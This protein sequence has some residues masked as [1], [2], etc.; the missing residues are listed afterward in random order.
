M[1]DLGIQRWQV[2]RGVSDG[3]WVASPKPT[4]GLID[5]L[6]CAFRAHS[7]TTHAQAIA[8]ADRMART[9]EGRHPTTPPTTKGHPVNEPI[10]EPILNAVRDAMAAFRE[11]AAAQNE[12]RK[13][14]HILADRKA[15]E[16]QRAAHKAIGVSMA[17]LRR[18]IRE[19]S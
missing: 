1:I 9:W 3:Q 14:F 6:W 17:R 16:R 7:F 18:T 13:A 8:Y 5:A 11:G 12:P 10:P 19:N 4:G 15:E 2:R